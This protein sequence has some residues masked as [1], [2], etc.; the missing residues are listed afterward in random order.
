MEADRRLVEHVEGAGEAGAERG[1]EVDALRLAAR[2]RARLAV[3][4]QVVE[5]DPVEHL[6]PLGELVEQVA[7]RPRAAGASTGARAARRG[8]ARRISA[9]SSGSVRPSQAHRQRL[10]LQARAAAVRAG[11]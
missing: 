5:P 4:G 9:A 7:A 11:L 2:E 6:D 1:G 10:G 3:E 8:A